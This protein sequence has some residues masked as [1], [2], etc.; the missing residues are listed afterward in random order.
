MIF[1]AAGLGSLLLQGALSRY[2]PPAAVPDFALLVVVGAGLHFTA[3][4]GMLV[5]TAIGFAADWLSGA[6]LGQQA[7][8]RLVIFGVTRAAN[9]RLHLR[10]PLPLGIFAAAA[11]A[12]NGTLLLGLSHLFQSGGVGVTPEWMLTLAVQA[13]ANAAC[14]PW[15]LRRL[16]HWAA[17]RASFSRRVLKLVATGRGA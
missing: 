10:R 17:P 16:A 2:L 4:R 15:L 6:L 7:L 11:T 8:L 5:S 13:L 12:A 3:A 9:R 1:L 14:A